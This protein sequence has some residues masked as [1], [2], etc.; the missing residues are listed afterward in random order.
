MSGFG[1]QNSGRTALDA[2]ILLGTVT[3]VGTGTGVTSCTI[4]GNTLTT[5]V[6]GIAMLFGSS[7]AITTNTLEHNGAWSI[8]LVASTGNHVESNAVAHNDYEGIVLDNQSALGGSV[9]D[10]GSTGNFIRQTRL[11][12]WS[13][14][15]RY[16]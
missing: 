5:S 4:T 10:Q 2:G 16:S 14:M 6:N 1:V 3:G 13:T 11:P 15:R 8:L 12:T 9:Y 7:N